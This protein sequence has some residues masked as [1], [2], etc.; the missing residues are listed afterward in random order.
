MEA[1]LCTL[2]HSRERRFIAAISYFDFT[3]VVCST[4]FV[5]LTKLNPPTGRVS[6]ITALCLLEEE[7]VHKGP[8]TEDIEAKGEVGRH[9]RG[10]NW[11]G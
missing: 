9:L 10:E 2:A 5:S 7:T 6:S 4:S 8:K 3:H 11:M 1:S